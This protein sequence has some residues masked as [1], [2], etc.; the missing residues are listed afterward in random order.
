MRKHLTRAAVAGAAI[1]VAMLAAVAA[2]TTPAAATGVKP[3]CTTVTHGSTNPFVNLAAD[4][5]TVTTGTF[6]LTT[7]GVKLV[8]PDN[9]AKVYGYLPLS[10]EVKLADID[11]AGFKN[12]NGSGLAP[13]YQF[14]LH[15]GG[16]WGG[17]LA[18]EQTYQ[19]A[20]KTGTDDV[21]H[22]GSSS[23]YI[24]KNYPATGTPT[25]TA[26]TVKTWDEI[27]ALLPKDTTAFYYGLNQGAGGV[28]TNTVDDLVL[29][30]TVYNTEAKKKKT[31]CTRHTWDTKYTSPS[32]SPSSSPSPSASVSPAVSA[33]AV[34]T[35]SSSPTSALPVT[36]PETG[37]IMFFGLGAV[38]DG[39]L[40][41]FAAAWWRRR[42]R[43]R[44][45]A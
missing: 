15:I 28:A 42:S 23:W 16:Q 4:E 3:G 17:T 37:R 21:L 1:A 40:L 33:T 5:H 31:T 30:T 32:P 7:D 27:L 36:G 20:G 8:T 41:T 14:G 26:H 10:P 24:T 38:I 9:A 29:Q 34:H 2:S 44:F 19:P 25:Y 22:H 35:P 18:W 43:V 45:T 39:V 6:T 13:S 11:E 12:I